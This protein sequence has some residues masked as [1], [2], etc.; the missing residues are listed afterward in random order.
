M[1]GFVGPA[2]EILRHDPPDFALAP[3]SSALD[4]GQRL[5]GINDGFTGAAPDLGALE[6]GCPEPSY[7]PRPDGLEHVTSLIN[8][9]G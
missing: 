5:P 7:G 9:G 4:R 2:D 8:C 1:G 6:A 3:L